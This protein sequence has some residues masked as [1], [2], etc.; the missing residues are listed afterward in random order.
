MLRGYWIARSSR[1]MTIT[2]VVC[3]VT[4]RNKRSRQLPTLT[5]CRRKSRCRSWQTFPARARRRRALRQHLRSPQ[6]AYPTRADP[7]RRRLR[8]RRVDRHSGPLRRRQ[9]RHACSASASSSRTR[10][11]PPGM[12]ATRDVLG[13]PRDGY[14]LLLCTHFESINTAVYRNAQY[15]LSRSRADLADLEILLRPCALQRGAGVGPRRRSSRYAKAHPGEISYGTV[16][17]GSA[18]E[19]FAR[20]L[21]RLAGITMNRVPYRG[22]AQVLQDLLP[23]R[24]QFYVSPMIS[25]IP[26]ANEGSVE[27][28]RG[29]E[30][31]APRCRA[32]TCRP[33]ANRASISSASAGSASA[34]PPARRRPSS[35]G[36]IAHI[37]AIVASPDYRDG[38]RARRLD[39]RV[40]DSGR[41]AHDHRA[42][43]RRRRGDDPGVRAAAGSVRGGNGE[44]PHALPR[45]RLRNAL[46]Y[47]SIRAASPGPTGGR[48][49]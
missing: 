11:R 35:A 28:A 44:T 10:P 26:L 34:P 43:P 16:G 30:P 41:T 12:L 3:I 39:S 40:V 18:Q 45:R 21:E 17:T 33:C 13:Q 37:A 19:I 36:S 8:R 6:D 46:P 7:T 49:A 5:H 23:G 4:G 9:A 15:E 25:I 2:G 29:V 24:V 48:R 42:D 20:Q 22:G 47:A 32:A 27:D 1:A 31:G 38:H 14:N